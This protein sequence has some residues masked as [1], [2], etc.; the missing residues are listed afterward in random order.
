MFPEGALHHEEQLKLAPACTGLSQI[1]R[2]RQEAEHASLI[3]CNAVPSMLRPWKVRLHAQLVTT[4]GAGTGVSGLAITVL[5]GWPLLAN[6]CDTPLG[7]TLSLQ[8]CSKFRT[9]TAHSTSCNDK[10]D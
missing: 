3:A 9:E 8:G 6:A 1:S 2:T 7:G 10:S 4:C 5:E